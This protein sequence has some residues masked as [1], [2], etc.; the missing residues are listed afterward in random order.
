MLSPSASMQGKLLEL[1]AQPGC[2]QPLE[3]DVDC[4]HKE[5]EQVVYALLPKEYAVL[6]DLNMPG[7]ASCVSPAEAHRAGVRETE[8]G[9]LSDSH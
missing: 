6:Q 8:V 7:S 4:H 3:L 2:S 9:Q 1:V 5:L